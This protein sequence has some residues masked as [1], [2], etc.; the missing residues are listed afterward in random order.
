MAD[1]MPQRGETVCLE[2]LRLRLRLG[3]RSVDSKGPRNAGT[4]CVNT[5]KNTDENESE[6]ILNHLLT[7]IYK[8]SC[9]VLSP[10]L[11]V[12]PL[13]FCVVL[14]HSQ[15]TASAV[16]TPS[17]TSSYL[18][19]VFSNQAVKLPVLLHNDARTDTKV[20]ISTFSVRQHLRVE[21][22][23]SQLSGPEAEARVGPKSG[24]SLIS[25][26]STSLYKQMIFLSQ[27]DIKL[28]FIYLFSII[29]HY[30]ASKNR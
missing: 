14:C 19:I 17:P 27:P 2:S 24:H 12:L 7:C 21:T 18:D 4:T 25:F 29:Y 11:S 15:K 28:I 16:I 13:L 1:A 6:S 26:L 20:F 30:V 8:Y 5:S 23:V 10:D 3:R 22:S 9:L